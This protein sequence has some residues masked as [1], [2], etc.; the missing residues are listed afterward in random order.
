MYTVGV[1]VFCGTHSRAH[2][3]YAQLI[4]SVVMDDVTVEDGCHIQNS[5][6]CAGSVV[7]AGGSLKDCTVGP[8]YV[9]AEGLDL[10]DEVLTV[11]GV[12]G[13]M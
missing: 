12:G 9:V 8:G 1:H 10:K 13:S 11:A 2:T 3:T 6:L 5:V 4:N 7:H